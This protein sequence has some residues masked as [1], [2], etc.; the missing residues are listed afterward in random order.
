MFRRRRVRKAARDIADAQGG[1]RDAAARGAIAF[2]TEG[3]P[4]RDQLWLK[5]QQASDDEL[6]SLSEANERG[7][8]MYMAERRLTSGEAVIDPVAVGLMERINVLTRL[9]AERSGSV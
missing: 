1:F 2:A 4:D 8:E 5:Y 9:L 3:T 6:R 7:L